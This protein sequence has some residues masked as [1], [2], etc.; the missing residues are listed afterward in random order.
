MKLQSILETCAAAAAA[1]EQ[2]GAAS[3]DSTGSGVQ[4]GGSGNT[5]KDSLSR[6]LR[7]FFCFFFLSRDREEEEKKVTSPLVSSRR[8]RI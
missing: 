1:A 4:K 3:A 8:N 5:H 2:G 6:P 7:L